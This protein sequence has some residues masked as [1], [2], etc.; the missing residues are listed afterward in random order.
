MTPSSFSILTFTHTLFLRNVYNPIQ[1]VTLTASPPSPHPLASHWP[2]HSVTSPLPS[3]NLQPHS[4]H[5]Q[6]PWTF[7]TYRQPPQAFK[8]SC[9]HSVHL[10]PPLNTLTSG[11]SL[12]V[13]GRTLHLAV[14]LS[15]TCSLAQP[16]D[17]SSITVLYHAKNST[18]IPNT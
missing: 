12:R 5:L 1:M 16:A 18:F 17:C 15:P 6:T 8:S 2:L 14:I 4:V 9:T 13:V 3:P 10:L 7:E 11:P